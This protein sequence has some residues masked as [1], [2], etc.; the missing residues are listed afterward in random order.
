MPALKQAYDRQLAELQMERDMLISE[1][2]AIKQVGFVT[3]S[4]H[5]CRYTDWCG[6]GG[7]CLS[8]SP[9]T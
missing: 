7:T 6:R 1:R 3:T 4:S 2:Q 8:P 5:G 9:P